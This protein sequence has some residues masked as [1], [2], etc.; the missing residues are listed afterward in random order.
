MTMY[1]CILFVKIY[2]FLYIR[3]THASSCIFTTDSI[4]V[5]IKYNVFLKLPQ[6]IERGFD[7]V[8]NGK[9]VIP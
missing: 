4:R 3:S 1:I 7:R 5:N 8:E 9:V 2:I 6:V